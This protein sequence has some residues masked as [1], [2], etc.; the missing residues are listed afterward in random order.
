MATVVCSAPPG[1]RGSAAEADGPVYVIAQVDIAN[2]ME[3]QRY[4]EVALRVILDNKGKTLVATEAAQVLEG[5][6]PGNW[7]VVLEFPS[8]DDA[9]RWYASPVYQA[10]IPIR[11]AAA[12][13]TNIAMVKRYRP[14]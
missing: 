6:W 9:K 1:S 12:R 5:D 13:F 11:H 4:Q 14:G 3:F 10:A 7:T 2:A 8:A